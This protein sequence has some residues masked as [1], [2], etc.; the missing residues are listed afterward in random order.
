MKLARSTKII[1]TLVILLV[2][3][4]LL[5]SSR[6]SV[7]GRN[8]SALEEQHKILSQENEIFEQKIASNSSLLT[9]RFQ[10]KK[11]GFNKLA[12]VLFVDDAFYVVQR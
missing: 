9:I 4:Q 2:I 3:V 8:L 12:E 5:V 10:A 11:L 1:L 7:I 6:L